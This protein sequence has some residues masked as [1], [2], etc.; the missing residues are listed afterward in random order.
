AL[1]TSMVAVPTIVRAEE[2]LREARAHAQKGLRAYNLGNF[3][4][5]VAEFSKAYEI[6]PTPVLLYNL[7]HAHRGAG[8]YERALFF[9]QRFVA[10]SKKLG[11]KA[12]KDKMAKATELI[13]QME[14]KLAAAEVNKKARQNTDVA[15][16]PVSPPLPSSSSSAAISGKAEA[17]AQPTSP[18]RNTAPGSKPATEAQE[19]GAASSGE[20]HGS[21]R[22]TLAWLAGGAAV[23]TL[24]TGLFFQI[25][26]SGKASD[27]NPYCAQDAGGPYP[28]VPGHSECAG[29]YNDWKSDSRWALAGYL[30]GAAFAITSTVLF[31]TSRTESSGAPGHAHVDCRPGLS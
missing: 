29:L 19:P 31:V 2:G 4:E 9:Y 14:A 12:D 16:P 20:H 11:D 18:A 1:V 17:A 27:F 30:A 3:E 26:A 7:G 6:D 22:R 13:A 23:V 10:E 21:F 15:P 5:A 28:V 25:R 24:G 8:N